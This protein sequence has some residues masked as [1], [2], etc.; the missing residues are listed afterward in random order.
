M[1]K[2]R[3]L[4]GKEACRILEAHGFTQIR[5]HGSHIVMQQKGEG[6][7]ITV[8]SPRGRTNS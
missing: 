8:L 2:L 6:T 7:T 5:Q 4:S 1:V 3:V